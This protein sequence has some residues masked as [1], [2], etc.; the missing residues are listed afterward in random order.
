[1][2]QITELPLSQTAKKQDYQCDRG[3][4]KDKL[5]F[6]RLCKPKKQKCC[7]NFLKNKYESTE[8]RVAKNNKKERGPIMKNNT[9]TK[10]IFDTEDPSSPGTIIAKP[11]S[12]KNTADTCAI[13]AFG[14]GFL[15]IT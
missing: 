7:S 1:M 15:G 3:N 8:S 10:L 11:T 4:L 5:L 2:S 13:G 14:H 6:M 9:K 12:S